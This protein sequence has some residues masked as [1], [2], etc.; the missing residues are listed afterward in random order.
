MAA[1]KIVRPGLLTTVQDCGRWGFQSRGVPVS[2]AMDGYSHRVAN[3]LVGNDGAAATLEVTLLGP[4]IEFDSPTSFAVAGAEF[5][6]TLEDTAVPMNARVEARPRSCLRFGERMAGARAYLAVGGGIDVPMVLNSRSTHLVS[7]LGGYHGR[8]LRAGDVVPIA[9]TT[10]PGAPFLPHMDRDSRA[11]FLP[12]AGAR[13]RVI[14]GPDGDQL[15]GKRYTVSTRS[16][17][18]GYRLEGP[19][20]STGMR[21]ETISSAVPT[22]AIQVPPG[23]QPILLMADHATVGGYPIAATVIAADLPVAGQ[24]AP[25]DWIEFA[26][27]SFEAADSAL[28]D[29]SR[30]LGGSAW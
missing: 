4:Q 12:K 14:A 25:G 27:C 9:D 2:G 23:G 18:M 20:L 21:S 6:L 16:D 17:R 26:A 3:R 11:P 30:A 28:R 19:A 22:G 7:A 13:L 8:A 15:A 24:L 1:L 5:R 29:R 10:D